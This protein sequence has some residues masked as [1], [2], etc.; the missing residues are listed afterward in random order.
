M[1]DFEIIKIATAEVESKTWGITKQFL[2][3]HEL[4]HEDDKLIVARIDKD[5]NDGEAIVYFPVKGEKFYLAI[6]VLTSPTLEIIGVG[7]E[8]HH[9]I[10]LRATSEVLSFEELS[11][12]TSLK[13][14]DG[15][16]KGDKRKYGNSVYS[17]SCIEFMPNPEPDEFEDKIYKLLDFLDK[18]KE[19]VCRLAAMANGHIQVASV[20]HNGNT[21]LGG[22]H[23]DKHLISRLKALDLEIDFDLY[24]EGSFFK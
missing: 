12:L 5:K 6:Y 18:D 8:P 13:P 23:L 4:A 16:N 24:A 3:I 9:K 21:I 17:F 14:T 2:E 10:F 19:G 22:F 7:T 20:F 1:N 11:K 15:W